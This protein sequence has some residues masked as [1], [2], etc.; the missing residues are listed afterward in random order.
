M[1]VAFG[2]GKTTMEV[3]VGT[4]LLGVIQAKP[5]P[6]ATGDLIQKALAAPIG[7]PPLEE[8]VKPGARVAIITSDITR[9]FPSQRVLPAILEKLEAAGVKPADIS[10]VFA[11]GI[12][13]EHTA[14]EM[15][16]LVGAAVYARYRCLDSDP[17]DCLLFG[18]TSRGTPVEITRVVAE[19][20]LRLSL[21]N[22]EYHYF[23]GYSGG[24][25][26]LMPGVASREAIA[27]N[28]S[29]MVL[30]LAKAGELQENPV[31]QDLEEALELCSLDF[32]FN[33]VLNETK[34]II[35]AVCGHPIAAHRAGCSILDSIYRVPIHQR[36][37]IVIASQGGA[38]K[39]LNLY[40]TQKA[41]DNA[42]QA[43][44]PGGIV[45]LVGSCAEGFGDE[46]FAQ[47]LASTRKPLELIQRISQDFQ[48]GG[49]KA[50][51]IAMALEQ[52]Q[53][54]LVSELPD[55]CLP[56]VESYMQPFAGLEAALQAAR[57]AKGCQVS[58]WAMPHGGSTLPY[59]VNEKA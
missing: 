30:P 7:S 12:H 33:V 11:L 51:A 2:F 21:G 13:R 38:P 44:K 27:N 47:W 36:A 17:N 15:E 59:V 46:T 43:V 40:Q 37:D 58:I 55:A 25:K 6:P 50:A 9:P 18:H 35:A 29:L 8:L 48:L 49:H 52:A 22:I 19:A 3:D 39:D 56:Y 45:I 54:Y 32:I 34:E 16:Q 5:L 1:R 26:G 14:T 28:H 24:V 31:R 23:A 20:D 57:A 4:E 42:V 53:V 10:I 41:L